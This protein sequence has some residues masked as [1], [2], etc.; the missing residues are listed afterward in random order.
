MEV[1]V[2]DY[3]G[4][5]GGDVVGLVGSGRGRVQGGV[6]LVDSLLFDDFFDPGDDRVC[7]VFLGPWFRADWVH[8]WRGRLT[9]WKDWSCKA[10]LDSVSW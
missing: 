6:E 1:E 4:T 5:P 8:W 10:R 2:G 3:V 7:W 9:H